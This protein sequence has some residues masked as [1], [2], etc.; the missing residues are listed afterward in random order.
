MSEAGD[1]A[2]GSPGDDE[3]SREDAGR[4]ERI[5]GS[6]PGMLFEYAL[7]PEGPGRLAYVSP[8]CREILE[9]DPEVLLRDGSSFWTLVHPDDRE[10]LLADGVTADEAGSRFTTEFRIVTPSGRQKWVNLAASAAPPRPG[11]PPTWSGIVTDVTIR[12]SA[13]AALARSEAFLRAIFDANPAA[14]A[15]IEPDTT[16]ALV[17]DAY[18]KLSGYGREE[19]VGRSWTTQVAPEDLARLKEYNRRRLEDPASAPDRYEFRF[20]RRDG[21]MRD[22]LMSISMVAEPRRIVAAFLDVT[23]RR[24]AEER[25]R[26]S[27]LRHRTLADNANDVVWTMGVDGSITYVSPSVEALRGFTPGEAMRQS[28]EEIHPPAS[29]AVSL[30]YFQKLHDDVAAG[31]PPERFRGEVEYRCKDGSTV[32][33]DVMAVPITGSDGKV[34]EILGVSRDLS[35]R[36]RA[37][38]ALRQAEARFRSLAEDAPV[39]I[40]ETGPDGTVRYANRAAAAIV[41]A[42]PEELLG[43]TWR[44]FVHPDDRERV[45]E[46][47][48]TAITWGRVRTSEYRM[49]GAGGRIAQV[50]GFLSGLF[51][52]D[53]GLRGFI[54]VDIDVTQEHALR[55]QLAVASRLAAVGT[56]VAGVAHEINNPLGGA[57]ASH[58]FVEEEARRMAA[59]LRSGAALD[60]EDL[61]A[62]LD[63]VMDALGDAQAGEKRIAAIVKDLTLFGRPDPARSRV[64]LAHVVENALRWIPPALRQRAAIDVADE[65]APDVVASEGQL[66]Q[67]VV[68]LVSNA[69]KAV[70]E[71]RTANVRIRLGRGRPGMARIDVSDDGVGITP[72]VMKRMFD[73]FFTTR[74]VGQGMGLGLAICHAIVTAHGGHVGATSEPGKGSTFRVELP[75]A[76][77]PTP[78]TASP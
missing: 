45:R 63:E 29:A 3:P 44:E 43:R 23:E 9:L 24:R 77:D 33:T 70:P 50:K 35:E 13:E 48:R 67:V 6:V 61:A 41:G 74:S 47:H 12:R 42:T 78:G 31:R 52:P 7:D 14:I 72:E 26:A 59:L 32:W 54:G 71:G 15:V 20:V 1:Q 57:L 68:N 39:G 8:A 40:L 17:N 36:K 53:G 58:G 27:E 25:V 75:A 19:I 38:E 64:P 51:G 46:D 22:C 56:L 18:C 76:P 65:D 34:V 2:G 4:L 10:R 21:E 69:V 30:G 73:P 62:R 11:R 5:A 55:E 16:I 49:V 37:E 28:L 60:R 66:G